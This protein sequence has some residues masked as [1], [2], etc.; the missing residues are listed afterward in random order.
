MSPKGKA[1][2]WQNAVKEKKEEKKYEPAK[3]KGIKEA[4]NE[5]GVK[6][7]VD[8]PAKIGKTI[9]AASSVFL[10]K[11]TNIS[12]SIPVPK[13]HPVVIIDT[14]LSAHWLGKFFKEEMENGKIIYHDVYVEN[15]KTLEVDPCASYEVFWET[16]IKYKD[17][18]E[19]TIVIDSLSDVFQWI[20]SYLR[21]KVLKMKDDES[22]DIQP[23]DWYWR[24]DKWESL[25]KF[26]RHR[27]CNVI[28]TCKVKD[29]WDVVQLAGQKEPKFQKT[30]ETIP[31]CHNTTGYW[32]DIIMEMKF[33]YIDGKKVRVA[34]VRGAR[35][36]VEPGTRIMKPNVVKVIDLL[37]NSETKLSW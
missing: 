10:A 11:N 32:F 28:I 26:L 27:K 24:N 21:I 18:E 5:S 8:G 29:D 20:N 17:M 15:E 4:N 19:G 1:S 33:E 9:F 34:Y 22:A 7:M 25:M 2:P 31:I 30:G 36:G 12:G 13:G 23:K 3:K 14:E 6:I 37:K 16:L 35:A